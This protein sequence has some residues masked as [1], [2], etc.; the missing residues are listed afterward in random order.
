M[1]RSILPLPIQC[2]TD[3]GMNN[4]GLVVEYA[5]EAG[6][7]AVVLDGSAFDGHGA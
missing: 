3:R 2:V 5:I 7:L 1:T 4:E 6:F